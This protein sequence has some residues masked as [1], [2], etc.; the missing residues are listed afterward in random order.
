MEAESLKIR[1]EGVIDPILKENFLELAD[2]EVVGNGTIIRLYVDKTGGGITLD[3]V[4]NFSRKASDAI[5]ASGLFAPG[6]YE[7]ETSSPGIN[8]PLRKREDFV[9]FAGKHAK[10][11][12]REKVGNDRHIFGLLNGISGDTV[13]LSVNGLEVQVDF[14]NIKKANLEEL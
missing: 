6:N 10:V 8:R 1:I 4:A 2:I 7:L 14:N 9:K 11:I 12:T 13:S 3:E 5:D